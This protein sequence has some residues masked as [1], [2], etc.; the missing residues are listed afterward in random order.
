MLASVK[1]LVEHWIVQARDPGKDPDLEGVDLDGLW[2]CS[3]YNVPVLAE[4]TGISRRLR[5]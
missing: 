4:V 1:C 3:T 5:I 2:A